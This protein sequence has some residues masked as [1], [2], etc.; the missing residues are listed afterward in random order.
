MI[1][2]SCHGKNTIQIFTIFR[3]NT[4]NR[5]GN[6]DVE[7]WPVNAVWHVQRF[8]G[9]RTEVRLVRHSES[10]ERKRLFVSG[11]KI[12]KVSIC[13]KKETEMEVNQGTSRYAFQFWLFTMLFPSHLFMVFDFTLLVFSTKSSSVLVSVGRQTLPCGDMVEK[14]LSFHMFYLR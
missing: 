5:I 2:I 7:R 3:G 4:T 9:R 14:Y 1:C 12:A 8:N 6:L 10:A 13:R 11:N